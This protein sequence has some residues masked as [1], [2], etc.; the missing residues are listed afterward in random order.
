MRCHGDPREDKDECAN[1]MRG[2][3]EDYACGKLGKEDLKPEKWKR[4]EELQGATAGT[5]CDISCHCGV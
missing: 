2:I 4:F 1:L 5:Q 3:A